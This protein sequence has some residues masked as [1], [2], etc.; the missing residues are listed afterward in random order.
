MGEVYELGHSPGRRL[1]VLMPGPRRPLRT[2]DGAHGGDRPGRSMLKAPRSFGR[3]SGCWR[4]PRWLHGTAP[5]TGHR[6]VPGDPGPG[7]C[8]GRSRSD[9]VVGSRQAAARYQGPGV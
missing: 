1:V 4:S 3:S 9:A 2:P 5:P 7:G 6:A 8:P